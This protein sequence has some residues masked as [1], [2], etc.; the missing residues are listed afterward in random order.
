MLLV[1]GATTALAFASATAVYAATLDTAATLNS[2]ASTP[3]VVSTGVNDFAISVWATG[4]VSQSNTATVTAKYVMSSDGTITPSTDPSDQQAL[5]FTDGYNYSQCPA[6]A[7]PEGCAAH[8]FT[9]TAQL[10]VPAGATGGTRGTLRV[11][12]SNTPGLSQDATPATGYVTVADSN[13]A[14]SMPGAPTLDP[15][16][17]SPNNTGAFTVDWAAAADP[18]SGDT[19]TYTL[20]QRDADDAGWTTVAGGLTGTSYTFA[21][22][23]EGSW[24]YQVQA[25]D[26]DGASS[27]FAADGTP[28]VVVDTTAPNPPTAS[29]DQP[30]A[31]IDDDGNAWYKDGVTVSFASAG[32]PDLADGSAGSGVAAVSSPRSFS[33]TGSFTVSGHATDN[34]TNVSTDT[35][36]SGYVDSAA[37]TVDAGCPTGTVLLNAGAA[38]T[39][40]ASDVGSGLATPAQGSVTLDTS[41]VGDH[42]IT[43]PAAVD[44]VGHS[45][46]TTD[47]SYHVGY[48]FSG[49]L[50]P[51]NDTAHF[52]GETTSVFKAGS[53]VPVKFQLL[54]A[55][56][57]AVQAAAAP[58]WLSPAEGSAVPSS[59]A[60]DE[61][62]YDIPASSGSFFKW[63][64]TS[65]QYV[66]NYKAD[67]SQAGHFWRIGVKLD[68]GSVQYVSVALR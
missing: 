28:I 26:S 34:A 63:D 64:A 24:R 54:D 48:D 37:P 15:A 40:T 61:S 10:V 3:S 39:W 47:C 55:N 4:K 36:L 18:D 57:V 8:P 52:V 23:P 53:T 11:A 12:T 65:R 27:A 46:G 30:A 43:V 49:F 62:S 7:P 22:E 67:K 29:A 68:D 6:A 60:V 25:V 41:T 17:T 5:H 38:A 33:A 20:Q 42:T 1:T 58:A 56:G 32:D 21:A 14:P 50:Q 2:S 19:V 51:I 13:H 59:I 66:F 16:S 44:N 35:T 31:Y 45:S 9:I